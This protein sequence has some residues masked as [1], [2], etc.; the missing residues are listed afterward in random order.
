MNADE[1]QAMQALN[2]AVDGY[3]ERAEA[4]ESECAS[5]RAEMDMQRRRA[6]HHQEAAEALRSRLAAA[7]ALLE[8]A[9]TFIPE[10]LWPVWERTKKSHLAA[11]PAT[12][13][14]RTEA[15]QRVLDA[16]KRAVDVWQQGGPFNEVETIEA[17]LA[18]REAK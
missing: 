4:A 6:D 13:P 16:V 18:R 12:A 9:T 10:A 2:L 7:N 14:A 3:R 11:Q 1:L 5:L 15:E 8:A 17:D